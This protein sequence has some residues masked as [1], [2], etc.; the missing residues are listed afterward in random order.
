MD[1]IPAT[2]SFIWCSICNDQKYDG[3][4]LHPPRFASLEDFTLKV[5]KSSVAKNAGGVVNRGEEIKEGTVFGP[6]VGKFNSKASYKKN[7]EA[8][9][10]S[11]NAW[12]I[13]DQDG[14]KVIGSKLY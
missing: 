5:E 9:D 8:G 13:K 12:E 2:D 3:C 14:L 7:I 11:G 10:E 1:Q 4:E 6:Y